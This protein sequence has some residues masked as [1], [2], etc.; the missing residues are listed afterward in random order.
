MEGGP[1]IRFDKVCKSFPGVQALKEITFEVRRGELHAIVGENGAGKSTLIRLLS[2]AE[3]A[4][5]GAVFV[6]GAPFAPRSPRDALAAGISTIYQV[7]SL[8]ADQS[9]ARN[10]YLGKEP[11]RFGFW[12]DR[13]A[14]REG[15][16]EILATLNAPRLSPDAVVG[17]LRVGEQQ[18]VETAKA[19]LNEAAILVMDEPTSALNAAE[20]EA[21]FK[22]VRGLRDRGVTILYISHHLEEVFALADRVTVMRDGRH[23]RTAPIGA[24]TRESLIFDMIGRD[25]ATELR[26][27]TEALGDVLLDVK[28]LCAGTAVRDV[29]FSVR[30]GE[31][32]GVAGLSGSGK[33]ELGKALFGDLPVKAGSVTLKGAPLVPSPSRAIARGMMYLPEDRKNDSLL[34]DVSIQRNISLAILPRISR[35]LGILRRREESAAADRQTRA[36]SIKAGSTR[37]SVSALS[38]GNQQKVALARCFA[39]E[40]DVLILMEPTQGI[41]IGVK[42]EFYRFITDA[43]RQGRAVLLISS[44]IAEIQILAHRVMVMRDGRNAA[45]LGRGEMSQERILSIALGTRSAGDTDAAAA[46]GRSK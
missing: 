14:M 33:T 23:V 15:T 34:R 40:P 27:T 36:L 3:Q 12:L 46:T 35:P 29:S 10:V 16:L 5:G 28:G 18:I 8:L 43:A 42:F 22:N 9:V 1:I 6:K 31:V 32:L 44:E 37:T 21:L 45:I 7:F 41:D 25:V 24:F 38:G 26:P 4:D 2:G 11:A 39:A 13:K 19:L 17:S 20:T 30:A